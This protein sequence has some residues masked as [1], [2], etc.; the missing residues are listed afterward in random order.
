MAR[1]SL[2]IERFHTAFGSASPL[3]EWAFA[4]ASRQPLLA[5]R[6]ALAERYALNERSTVPFDLE[7][8]KTHRHAAKRCVT[9]ELLFLETFLAEHNDLPSLVRADPEPAR[10]EAEGIRCDQPPPLALASASPSCQG[11][12]I[13][14][15]VHP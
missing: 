8:P 2:Y 6:R 9:A 10:S 7:Y 3:S 15:D 13:A 5:A 12:Q 14:R 11:R 4:P 1:F